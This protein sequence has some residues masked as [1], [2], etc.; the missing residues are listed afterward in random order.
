MVN[1]PY[2]GINESAP[3]PVECNEAAS[4]KAESA[5]PC[6]WPTLA[7]VFIPINFRRIKGE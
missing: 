4:K 2:S 6:L 7:P 3:K 5:N 1:Y